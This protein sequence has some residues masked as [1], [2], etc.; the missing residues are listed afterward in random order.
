MMK[1]CT[2]VGVLRALGLDPE[3]PNDP[4]VLYAGGVVS[5]W[6]DAQRRRELRG[7]AIDRRKTAAHEAGHVVMALHAG[8]T[9]AYATTRLHVHFLGTDWYAYTGKMNFGRSSVT[10]AQ[11]RLVAVAGAVG[12]CAARL[13][14]DLWPWW[15][16]NDEAKAAGRYRSKVHARRAVERARRQAA[17][18]TLEDGDWLDYMS[19]T[20]R[21]LAASAG[22]RTDAEIMDAAIEAF[23]LLNPIDGPLWPELCRVTRTLVRHGHVSVDLLRESGEVPMMQED[24][25][26]ATAT[27]YKGI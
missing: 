26:E 8:A 14:D 13:A 25:H 7:L 9:H 1:F 11:T 10:P 21:E 4:E 24:P 20:D 5:G 19:D 16:P 23:L 18:I 22:A 6:K 27:V 15:E 2:T 3:D 17:E 12:Y